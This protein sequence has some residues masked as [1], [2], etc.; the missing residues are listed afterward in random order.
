MIYWTSTSLISLYLFASSASYLFH[1]PTMAGIRDLGFPDFFRIELAILKIAAGIVIL[2]P[3][4]PDPMKEWAYAGIT[5]FLLT[6]IIAHHA[7][8]DPVILNII[9]LLIFIVLGV[10]YTSRMSSL[11]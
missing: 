5:L 10:S 11:P 3:F 8:G 7:H 6:A 2:L 9:N 4:T 1:Q